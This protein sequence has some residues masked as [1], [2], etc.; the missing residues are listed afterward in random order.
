MSPCSICISSTGNI[1]ILKYQM[2]TLKEEPLA[3]IAS[4]NH[5]DAIPLPNSLAKQ[6]IE[7]Q[8]PS[9]ELQE[10]PNERRM[11]AREDATEATIEYPT[12]FKFAIV[13]VA[14]L[15]TL[16]LVGLV[17]LYAATMMRALSCKEIVE[18]QK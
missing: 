2:A 14:T 13:I 15:L 7:I 18:N 6:V 8:P 11:E 17:S 3:P 10:I 12:G 16:V 1:A 5:D 4:H 9:I